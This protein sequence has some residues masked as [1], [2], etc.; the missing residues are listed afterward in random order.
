MYLYTYICIYIYIYIGTLEPKKQQNQQHLK[1]RDILEP[2][3]VI[4]KNVNDI[5]HESFNYL[6]IDRT[7]YKNID[8]VINSSLPL[9][10][11]VPLPLSLPLGS[12][13]IETAS[14]NSIIKKS[15]VN[16]NT[17]YISDTIE[18]SDK[19]ISLYPNADWCMYIYVYK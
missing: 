5:Y 11:S 19:G 12:K 14:S 1:I 7:D 15:T 9:P 3:N 18:N 10:P 17:A 6:K 2:K 8:S 4:S 16:N 13:T